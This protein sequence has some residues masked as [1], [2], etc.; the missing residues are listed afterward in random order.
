MTP[1]YW[2]K[3][4]DKPLFPELEWSRPETK[5]QAGKLLIIGGNK[6]GFAAPA[7]AYGVAQKA[8]AGTIRVMLPASL[9]RA[10][11]KLFPE[12]E[13]A[14]S[15]ISGSFATSALAELCG[16][17]MWADGVLFPGDIS[18]N[19]ETTVLLESYLGKYQHQV[20]LTKDVADLLCQQP[21]SILHRQETLLVLALGQ[22]QKLGTEAHFP[23]A[24]TS[25]LGLVQLADNLHE[26]TKRF[27]LH[28][29]TR[30]QGQLI[31]AANGRI[32]TTQIKH[33]TPVWR[34]KTAATA[35]VWWLQNPS[36]SFEA[37]TTALYTIA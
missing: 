6:F 33:E 34:L 35:S 9:Q 22:L 24:F 19:S 12:A 4:A 16:A 5:S 30:H 20:T 2:L 1:E 36:K 10:V 28:I 37:I 13:F 32:S 7:S 8:G 25:Q 23:R 26:F 15:T 17:S 31:V 27:P 14:P 18:R 3:Q 29:I 21:T 11:G